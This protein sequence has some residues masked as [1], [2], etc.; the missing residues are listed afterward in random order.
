M[1]AVAAALKK[2]RT[3][4]PL[5]A[6]I[7]G[8]LQSAA[9]I[10]TAVE[11]ASDIDEVTNRLIRSF[12][13]VQ[14]RRTPRNYLLVLANLGLVDLGHSSVR[15]TRQGRDFLSRRDPV[16]IRNALITRIAGVEELLDI[17]RNEH[18]QISL[19]TSRLRERG[20]AWNTQSQVHYRLR[21]LEAAGA[22]ERPSPQIWRLQI[23]T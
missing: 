9:V 16:I 18:G 20:Y 14:S 11:S 1:T 5:P 12:P 6:G 8:Y 17:L 7:G 19:L 2:A 15:L 4:W 22:V 3:L 21:W 23:G 10:L 13:E